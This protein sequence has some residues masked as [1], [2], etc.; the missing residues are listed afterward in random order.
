[1]VMVTIDP[2]HDRDVV[3]EYVQ[4]FVPGAHAV[5]LDDD[6]E[7]RRLAESFGVTYQVTERS[8]GDID[9]VH[10]DTTLFAVDDTGT[11]VLTWPFGTESD[12]LAGDLRQLLDAGTE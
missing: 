10:S 6:T 9:V 8:N 3:T 4:G 1:M 7:L 5:A 2:D 12:D 11:L